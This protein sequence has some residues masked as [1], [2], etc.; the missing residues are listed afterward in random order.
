MKIAI[1]TSLLSL[2]IMSFCTPASKTPISSPVTLLW[3]V[4]TNFTPGNHAINHLTLRNNGEKTLKEG[5]ALFFNFMRLIDPESITGPAEIAHINGDFYRLTLH[6]DVQALSPGEEIR[7]TYNVRGSTVLKA[8]APHGAYMVLENGDYA[9]VRVES[10]PFDRP[11]QWHRNANDRLPLASAENLYKQ[12]L[13]PVSFSANELVPVVPTPQL[14][15]G[16]EGV[17]SIGPATKIVYEEGLE[18]EA[19]FLSDALQTLGVALTLT[20]AGGNDTENAI[21]LKQGAVAVEGVTKTAGDEA[22][23]LMVAPSDI[24]ITGIDATGVFYG[25]QS[26]RALLPLEAWSSREKTLDVGAVHIEDAP[27]FPYRGFHLDVSRNFQPVEK[28]KKLLDVMAFYKLNKFHFHL[29]DDEGWR[30]AIAAF[31]E[32][33][34][35]GGRRGHTLDE[36]EHLLPSRGSGPDPDASPGSGWYTRAEYIDLLRYAAERHIE[37]IPEIDVPGHA[38]AAL[39][40]MQNRYERLIAQGKEEE[41]LRYRIH[42]PKDESKYRSVQRFDDNVI[43]VC[44]ESTYRFLGVVFDELLA[45]HK[46]ADVPLASIHVGGDEVPPGVWE[47]SPQCHSLIAQSENIDTADDLM[48]YFFVRTEALLSDRGLI[49]A[50]WEEFAL[51]D[52]PE[53]DGIMPNPLFSGRSI[54]YVWSNIWGSGRE[55]YSYRLANAGYEIVMSHASNFYFDL[56]YHKHPD[57]EGL[58]WAGF[59]NTLDPYAFI[60]FDLYKTTNKDH[61]GRPLPDASKENQPALTDKGR[62]NILGL[63]GQLWGETLQSEGRMEEM[64]LP[65]LLALAERAWN[66]EEAW[67]KH[68]NIEE[69]REALMISW[70]DFSHRLGM[71]EL[72]RLDVMNGGYNYRIPP[73]GA[74]IKKGMLKANVEHPGLT[75]RYTLDGSVPDENST[76]YDGPVDISQ[77]MPENHFDEMEEG[78]TGSAEGGVNAPSGREERERVEQQQGKSTIQFKVKLRTF[79]SRGRGSRVTEAGF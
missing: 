57:E 29:T 9:I 25:I 42:D 63:Q 15:R 79:D 27:G 32:L 56:A 67:M 33:T 76:R 61:M 5:W 11:E 8:D 52:N 64:A 28:V 65:R 30:L 69:R 41:A 2:M 34:E 37:V 54:P 19:R 77:H 47:R 48:D 18:R 10:G 51:S 12:Y 39:V 6:E 59:V 46:E 62:K 70:S 66:P 73:S 16:K 31:P 71:R 45:M 49:M 75:I 22:Y 43:N 21:H 72:P 78:G 35:I 36:K 4:E 44:Q 60:P 50:G 17:F 38:R 14:F 53:N 13:L 40:A 20:P 55:P 74:V 7:I 3:E 26:L 58:Y 1:F 68:D 23:R 24:T